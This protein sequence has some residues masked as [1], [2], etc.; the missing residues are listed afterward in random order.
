MQVLVT[1][2][3]GWTA[4]AIVKAVKHAGHK[5][6]AFDLPTAVCSDEMRALFD[7][8]VLGTIAVFADVYCAT[9]SIDAIIHLAVAINKDDY[10]KPA[11]PFSVNVQGAYN[12]FESARRRG[13][14]KIVLMSEAAVHVLH[15]EGE[16]LHAVTDW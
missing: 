7:K 2:A 12:V 4:A 13:I 11:I 5:V 8:V 14:Q 10:Q 3:F 16:Y 6:V 9:Q 1:G 15:P